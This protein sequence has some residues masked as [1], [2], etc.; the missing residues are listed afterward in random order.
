M[1]EKYS[2]IDIYLYTLVVFFIIG[3]I[4]FKSE[5]IRDEYLVGLFVFGGGFFFSL[6][7]H[8]VLNKR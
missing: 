2:W 7:L 3:I 1:S 5:T 4:L 6:F 8:K